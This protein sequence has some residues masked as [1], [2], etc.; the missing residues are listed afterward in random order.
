MMLELEVTV[1]AT[2]FSGDYTG[3]ESL[4]NPTPFTRWN[5]QK[6]QLMLSVM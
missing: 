1:D 5:V 6:T 3:R 2:G 4:M